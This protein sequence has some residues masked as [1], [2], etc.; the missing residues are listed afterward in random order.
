MKTIVILS[1]G[2]DS[3]VLAYY[4]TKS[5]RHSLLGC[6]SVDYGQ[7]HRV[8]LTCAQRTARKLGVPHYLVD[9]T[10]LR[11]LLSR[12]ALTSSQPVPEGHYAEDSMKAT[13][14]PNRNMILISIAVGIGIS[15]G[16]EVVAYGAH[17]GDHAI[18]PDCRPEF[19]EALGKAVNL[20]DYN[21]PELLRPFI[22]K[23]KAEIVRIGADLDVPF[24]DTYTCYNGG[25]LACGKCG[26]CVERLEAFD[27]AGVKDPLEYQDRE[28][29]KTVVKPGTHSKPLL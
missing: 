8:E 23:T 10:G 5:N 25:M 11:S 7:R 28:F 12:S 2:L 24:T 6:V 4:I 1:G 3:T 27:I 17:S 16:A 29:W 18:Y 21:P 15:K 20:C 19:A 9:L 14:V 26:T 13:V 22:H